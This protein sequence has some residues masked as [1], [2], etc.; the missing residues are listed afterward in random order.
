MKPTHETHAPDP[1]PFLLRSPAGQAPC[2][3]LIRAVA[4]GEAAQV[5]AL[6]A[7]AIGGLMFPITEQE[8]RDM[9]TEGQGC[10]LGVWVQDE[11]IAFLAITVPDLGENNLGR[12]AGLP[13]QALSG[14]AQ[15]TAVVVHPGYRGNGLHVRLLHHSLERLDWPR[16]RHWLATVRCENAFSLNNFLAVG[17]RVAARIRKYDGHERFVLMLELPA[18]CGALTDL[19]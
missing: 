19:E 3:A 8:V 11:L 6:Q 10:I 5:L 14:I 15:W 2:S 17:A 9:L 1:S 7:V 18:D 16:V 13:D 4:P 12:D